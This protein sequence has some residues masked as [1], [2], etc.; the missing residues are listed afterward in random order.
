MQ[1][2]QAM[3]NWPQDARQSLRFLAAARHFLPQQLDCPAELEM[4]YA[5]HL[6]HAEFQAALD[7]LE[8]IGD[9]HSG[10]EHESTFWK[11]L[12]YAAQHMALPEHAAR[13]AERLRQV[14]EMQ[15]LQF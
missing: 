11:E 14:A 15:R 6:R 13:F 5:S 10:Y 3:R 9:L 1:S 4:Q 12:Y 2:K 7:I 8:Q